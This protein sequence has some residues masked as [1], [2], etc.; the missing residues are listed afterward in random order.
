MLDADLNGRLG[1]FGLARMIDHRKAG[2]L[3]ITSTTAVVGTRGYL[4]PEIA[5]SG[6]ATTESDIFRFTTCSWM[7]LCF[8]IVL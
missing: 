2:D 3:S 1:D 5:I 8:R 4:A 7:H 6:K